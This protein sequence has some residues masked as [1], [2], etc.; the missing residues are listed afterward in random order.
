MVP[1]P[2]GLHG[3]VEQGKKMFHSYETRPQAFELGQNIF[4][5]KMMLKLKLFFPFG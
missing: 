3:R 2:K 4:P 5:E 1:D